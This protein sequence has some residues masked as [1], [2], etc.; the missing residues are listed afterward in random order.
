MMKLFFSTSTIEEHIINEIIIKTVLEHSKNSNEL[1]LVYKDDLLNKKAL[2]RSI[3][4][5]VLFLFFKGLFISIFIPSKMTSLT[6]EGINIGRY[7]VPTAYRSYKSYTNRIYFIFK[8][9]KSL[10]KCSLFCRAIKKHKKS[11]HLVYIDNPFYENG[12]FYD[13]FSGLNVPI[14]HNEYP[15]GLVRLETTK[16]GSYE[17]SLNVPNN[18]MF[19]ANL[20]RGKNQLK[21]VTK[22][23][24]KIPYMLTKFDEYNTPEHFD[25]V[26]YSHSFTDAQCLHGHDGAFNNIKEWMDYTLK[27]L[28]SSKVCVKGHPEI[29]TEGY[30]SQVVDWDRKLFKE[31]AEEYKNHSNITFI[32][33]PV[34]NAD[35]LESLSNSTVLIS[36]HGNA[37]LEGG[38]AGFKC[39]SSKATNWAN[40]EI[41]NEWSSKDEYKK[42][43]HKESHQLVETNEAELYKYYDT[44]V[45][46]KGSYFA[47]NWWVN[48]VAEIAAVE[49]SD[50][51]KDP[52]CINHINQDLVKKAVKVLSDELVTF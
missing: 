34:Q 40:Y 45:F 7:A 29:Y 36:H 48:R 46:G 21:I 23:T 43:L 39:I 37:L 9:L 14:Y 19:E 41:F 42:M 11:I 24:S 32:D 28:K 6:F 16:R 5:N 27:Q 35:L 50:I 20:E 1:N 31:F 47:T 4:L 2:F 26:I 38:A 10:I 49:A 8:Y 52:N 12:I 51:V 13:I 15:F 44:L 17:D 30:S 25:Y 18:E 22:D 3:S 33:Y